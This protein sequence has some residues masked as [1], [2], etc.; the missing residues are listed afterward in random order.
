[1]DTSK[2]KALYIQETHEHLSGIEKGLLLLDKEPGN[3]AAV[4]A[5]FRH[6]HSIKGMSASMGY[7]PVLRLAHAQEDLLDRV[8]SKKIVLTPEIVSTLLE[9]LDALGSLI[10]KTEGDEPL[11]TDISPFLDKIRGT[12]DA[13]VAGKAGAE[14]SPEGAAALRISDIMKV[15]SRVFD[16]L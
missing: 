15:E 14:P 4:D 2:Y 1:M 9:C 13:G 3:S 6:Y 12:P 16:D 8:R 7:E 11:D 10:R 5:L